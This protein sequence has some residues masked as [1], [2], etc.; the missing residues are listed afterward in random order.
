MSKMLLVS[1]WKRVQQHRCRMAVTI[2]IGAAMVWGIA[3]AVAQVIPPGT[4]CLETTAGSTWVEFGGA[5]NLPPLPADFFFPGSEPFEGTIDLRG[6]PLPGYVGSVNTLVERKEPAFV[7]SGPATIQ[8]ELI[9]LRLV[10][11]API[12]VGDG[13]GGQVLYNVGIAL[14]PNTPSEGFMTIEETMPSLGG[15][16]SLDAGQGGGINVYA[17][18]NFFEEIGRASCRERV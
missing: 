10:S 13:M 9:E 12:S 1:C 17:R 6:D 8:V 16:F 15:Q 18:F 2:A 4:D 14:N 7:S 11:V 3:G 5:G